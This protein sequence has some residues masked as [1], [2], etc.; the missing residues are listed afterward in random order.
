MWY[1]VLCDAVM[2]SSDVVHD[3]N[4]NR[5]L[6]NTQC[7]SSIRLLTQLLSSPDPTFLFLNPPPDPTF[8]RTQATQALENFNETIEYVVSQNLQAATNGMV[9]G[10]NQFS[11]QGTTNLNSYQAVH[12]GSKNKTH[13]HAVRRMRRLLASTDPPSA[14]NWRDTGRMTPVSTSFHV[15]LGR[16]GGDAEEHQ[17][18]P[19]KL[20]R[21]YIDRIILVVLA[22]LCPWYQT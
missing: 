17:E 8:L 7:P 11:D 3:N 1:F 16:G 10:F 15:V 19:R 4:H 2:P 21:L 20:L 6:I 18:L 5:V 22:L 13:P 9:V 14:V 12:L